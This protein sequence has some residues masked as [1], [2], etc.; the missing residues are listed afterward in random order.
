M[1]QERSTV[2]QQLKAFLLFRSGSLT[3]FVLLAPLLGLGVAAVLH[4]SS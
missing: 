3:A 2:F 4:P 1:A